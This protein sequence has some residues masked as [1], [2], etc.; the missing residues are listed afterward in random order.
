VPPAPLHPLMTWRQRGAAGAL[1]PPYDLAAARCRRR[2]YTP[3][4]PLMTWR[5]RGA[6]GALRVERPRVRVAHAQKHR[7]HAVAVL[8]AQV[9]AAHV[10]K[11]V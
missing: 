4:H 8:T 6:A 7:V 11:G 2:P 9:R 3:L 10:C 5:Q 1:T